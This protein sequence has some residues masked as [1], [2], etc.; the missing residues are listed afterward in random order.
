ML[1]FGLAKLA[2]PG[3]GDVSSNSPTMMGTMAGAVMGTVGYMSPEQAAGQ[4]ADRRTDI[5]ALGCVLY[6]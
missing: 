1:D 4:P 3:A 2:E 6:K 5:F